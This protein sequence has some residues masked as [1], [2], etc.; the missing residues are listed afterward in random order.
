MRLYDYEAFVDEMWK[1]QDK[2]YTMIALAGE[3]G[4]LLNI[5]KKSLRD[6]AYYQDHNKDWHRM[7][8]HELGDIL[9]YLTRVC[10]EHGTTLGAVMDANDTKLRLRHAGHPNSTGVSQSP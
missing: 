3:V 6:P 4:E 5:Y 1:G 8:V 10:H 2:N 9:Y 7:I